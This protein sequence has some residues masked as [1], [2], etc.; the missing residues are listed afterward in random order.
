MKYQEAALLFRL[1]AGR[2]IEHASDSLRQVA[3]VELP[4]GLAR[5]IDLLH[6]RESPGDQSFQ[7]CHDSGVVIGM[8]HDA[9]QLADHARR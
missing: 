6:G 2:R 1:R 9:A 3:S 7:G 5:Y 4:P 8:H